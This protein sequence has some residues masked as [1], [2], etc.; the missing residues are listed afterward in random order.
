MNET[1]SIPV[2]NR[3]LALLCRSLPSYLADVKAL[4]HPEGEKT[5]AALYRLVA[6]QRLYAGRVAEAIVQC[7]GQPNSGQF[8]TEFAAKND[9]SIEFLLREIV[10]GQ[11]R[12]VAEIAE[13]VG[14]LGAV[15][16][17][18][19]LAEEVLG[20]AKGHLEILQGLMKGR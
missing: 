6:D 20:N 8:P 12:D 18:H 15:S 2:L 10:T 14:R 1:E 5:R 3:L 4:G 7:G 17:L 9:L 11:E 16:A 19:A 13:C